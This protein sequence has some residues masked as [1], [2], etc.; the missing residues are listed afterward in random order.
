M[1]IEAYTA[2]LARLNVAVTA[3]VDQL[4][5][6]VDRMNELDSLILEA[7]LDVFGD[8]HEDVAVATAIDLSGGLFSKLICRL[9]ALV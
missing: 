2:E 9:G 8:E 1:A 4:E 3:M 5:P 7:T 6:M